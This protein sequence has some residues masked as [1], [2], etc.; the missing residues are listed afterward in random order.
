MLAHGKSR[1]QRLLDGAERDIIAAFFAALEAGVVSCTSTDSTALTSAT[2]LLDS[3]R[4]Y[5]PTARTLN[6]NHVYFQ[7]LVLVIIAKENSGP[8]H[9]KDTIWYHEAVR[10]GIFLQLHK[11]HNIP[12]ENAFEESL[13]ALGRRIWLVLA[14][15]DRWQ[16]ASKTGM[17][18][19]ARGSVQLVDS[20]EQ[21]MGSS[22]YQLTRE[23]V[24]P[25]FR[26]DVTDVENKVS[27]TS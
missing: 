3:L 25:A 4:L 23:H 9:A 21:L 15:L 1:Q 8:L 11:L 24:L 16:A 18:L 13:P 26:H 19:I 14:T 22:A 12:F 17:M 20:D 6:G 27:R 10:V 2:T 5:E 7:T